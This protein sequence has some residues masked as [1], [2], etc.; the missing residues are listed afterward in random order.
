MENIGTYW[1]K[2][3]KLLNNERKYQHAPPLLNIDFH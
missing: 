1:N 2:L 3:N